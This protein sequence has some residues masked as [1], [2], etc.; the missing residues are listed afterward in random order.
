MITL[1]QLCPV[2]HSDDYAAMCNLPRRGGSDSLRERPGYEY[3]P[4]GPEGPEGPFFP[5][6]W[7]NYGGPLPGG[8][9][10]GPE[11]P[12]SVPLFTENDNDYRPQEPPLRIPIHR[13]REFQPRPVDPYGG[14]Y[15]LP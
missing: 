14:G 6:Y 10:Y 11:V 3:S 12:H 4:E 2:Y 13:P 7:D 9:Y 5:S 15:M 1:L 8:T